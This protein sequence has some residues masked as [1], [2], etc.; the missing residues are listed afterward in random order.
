MPDSE[1]PRGF[2][3]SAVI[4][5]A[6]SSSIDARAKRIVRLTSRRRTGQD[7]TDHCRTI[8]IHHMSLSRYA[9]APAKGELQHLLCPRNCSQLQLS[10]S[11]VVMSL[12]CNLCLLTRHRNCWRFGNSARHIVRCRE[13]CA[14]RLKDS[15]HKRLLEE[16][17]QEKS[18]RFLP[19]V[20]P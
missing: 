19:S 12:P 5:L 2:R 14:P 3:Q 17:W 20:A 6:Y 8:S 4:F 7:F 10:A 16:C 13:A 1:D 9:S 18:C 11:D 15:S